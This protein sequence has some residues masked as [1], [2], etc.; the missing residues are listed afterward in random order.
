MQEVFI[1]AIIDISYFVSCEVTPVGRKNLAASGFCSG[2]EGDL[3]FFCCDLHETENMLN[4]H[5]AQL[6]NADVPSWQC[7]SLWKKPWQYL[8]YQKRSKCFF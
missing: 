3:S 1:F 8:K 4:V 7:I 6:Y 2:Q 5:V